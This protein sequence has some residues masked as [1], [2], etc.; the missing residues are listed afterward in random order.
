MYVAQQ[1][2]QYGR[3]NHF[4]LVIPNKRHFVAY[5]RLMRVPHLHM[6]NIF[7]TVALEAAYT[8]GDE[9]LAQLLKY[10]QAN[11]TFL[12]QFFTENIPAVKVMRPDATYLIWLDF[13]AFGLTDENL[14]NK[15]IN[16]GVGLNRGVQFGKQ[17]R[18]FMRIN[19]GCPRSVLQEALFR[20]QNA[21]QEL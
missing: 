17:G 19:I 12:E 9:W 1:N 2:L 14:N 8:H 11:Y 13:S 7:G 15:I 18:G 6:G 21:F 5:E 16:A 3:L 10:L 4:D 20:I